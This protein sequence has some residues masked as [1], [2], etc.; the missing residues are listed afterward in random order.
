M[1]KIF[2]YFDISI[3]EVKYLWYIHNLQYTYINI[4]DV[5]G[6]KV[7]YIACH[8]AS[9]SDILFCYYIAFFILVLVADSSV[10]SLTTLLL[11]C[12]AVYIHRCLFDA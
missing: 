10:L 3:V 11:F 7:Y 1:G 6:L 12:I 5:Y 8:N 9:L 2:C 4:I